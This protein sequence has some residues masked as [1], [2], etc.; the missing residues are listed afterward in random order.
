MQTDIMHKAMNNYNI[1]GCNCYSESKEKL[2][3]ILQSS[4]ILLLPGGN[5]EMFFK[6]VVHDTEIE[7]RDIVN[8]VNTSFSERT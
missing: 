6:K 8:S 2:K 7:G 4:N 1:I 5:P 3:N